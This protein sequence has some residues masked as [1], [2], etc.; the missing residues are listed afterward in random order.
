MHDALPISS[1]G[2][3]SIL[4]IKHFLL[5]PPI[6]RTI[7]LSRPLWG[8][9]RSAAMWGGKIDFSYNNPATN[10]LQVGSRES[11]QLTRWLPGLRSEEH[12]SELQSLMRIEYD[13]V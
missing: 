8:R 11:S 10:A 4:A 6:L 3:F 12:K 13:V 1:M 9:I 2:S 7:S 5:R